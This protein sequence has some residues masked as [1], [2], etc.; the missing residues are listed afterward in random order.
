[1]KRA[2]RWVLTRLQ[3]EQPDAFTAFCHTVWFID[4][5]SDGLIEHERVHRDQ[6]RREGWLY[7]PRYAWQSIRHGHRGNRYEVEAYAEQERVNRLEA[8]HDV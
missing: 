7:Y 6:Q 2:L 4:H 1:M 8:G 3:G 5:P